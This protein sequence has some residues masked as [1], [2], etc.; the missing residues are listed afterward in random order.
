MLATWP[1]TLPASSAIG[2]AA[3]AGGK[4]GRDVQEQD[5]AGEQPVGVAVLIQDL[6]ALPVQARHHA[7][8]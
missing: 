2:R 7:L 5:R 6:V 8:A 3:G 1:T 4:L